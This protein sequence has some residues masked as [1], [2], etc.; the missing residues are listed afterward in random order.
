MSLFYPYFL[1]VPCAQSMK[2]FAYMQMGS[3]IGAVQGVMV[4]GNQKHTVRAPP[5]I[6]LLCIRYSLFLKKWATC[7]ML[8]DSKQVLLFSVKDLRCFH[9]KALRLWLSV[10]AEST[11]VHLTWRFIWK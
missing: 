9:V 11:L 3:I 6:Y 8:Q 10:A 2:R 5:P 7:N 1:G 4:G